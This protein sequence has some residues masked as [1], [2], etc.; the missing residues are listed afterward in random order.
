MVDD[1]LKTGHSL[2]TSIFLAEIRDSN[3]VMQDP[4]GAEVVRI[5]APDNANHRE[6]LTV[7]SSN[8]VDDTEPSDSERDD[9]CTNAFPPSVAL[10]SVS[11][12]D[13]VA[14]SDVVDAGLVD[15]MVQQ[16]EVEISGHSED[17][18][19]PNFNKPACKMTAQAC[20]GFDYR[21]NRRRPVKWALG[22][23]HFF[24][25]FS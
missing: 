2:E 6:I 3:G 24:G 9:H 19:N 21:V 15:K 20:G 8:G 1:G 5:R 11:G 17:V 18:A 7:C 12:V 10:S 22:V 25:S 4:V 13:L 23:K 16:D 14:A